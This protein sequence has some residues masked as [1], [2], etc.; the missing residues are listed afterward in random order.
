MALDR[1]KEDENPS[2]ADI[3]LGTDVL[4]ISVLAIIICA[5]IGATLMA[6][7]GPRFLVK[8]HDDE[9][10]VEV[11]GKGGPSQNDKITY[12]D[13]KEGNDKFSGSVE[14]V[15]NYVKYVS[16][17]DDKGVVIDVTSGQICSD[18]EEKEIIDTNKTSHA[19]NERD[20]KTDSIETFNANNI[21]NGIVPVKADAAHT[22]P[23]MQLYAEQKTVVDKQDQN[24]VY[25]TADVD[26]RQNEEENDS[27]I[28]KATGTADESTD[29]RRPLYVSSIIV[30]LNDSNT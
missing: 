11:H 4:T 22:A 21:E 2:E 23:P 12:S 7:L 30:E 17:D 18:C 24:S 15:L 1:V 27:A 25:E 16:E 13:T 5:P 3:Q 29:N 28:D 8:G 14:P 20:Y 26:M 6:V 9:E 19:T 10:E